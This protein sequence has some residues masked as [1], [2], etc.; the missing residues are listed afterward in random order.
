MAGCRTN[1]RLLWAMPDV[2]VDGNRFN[3]MFIVFRLHSLV[4]VRAKLVHIKYFETRDC[5]FG[6]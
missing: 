4:F 1:A 5:T 3:D 6:V 2:E